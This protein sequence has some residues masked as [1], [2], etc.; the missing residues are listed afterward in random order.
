MTTKR[1]PILPTLVTL[2]NAFCGFTAIDY[3]IRAS[4]DLPRFYHWIGWSGG[5]ILLAMVF[6]ALDGKIARLAHAT[7]DLGRELDSLC[8][9]IS[10]GV[11]PAVIV[12]TLATQQHY[13]P[14]LGW[15]ASVLFVM[16]A[17]LRLARF[18]VETDAAEESHWHFKG[19]PSPAA[20]GF[21][22]ALAVNL[23]EVRGA[24]GAEG[25]LNVER[26]AFSGARAD[27]AHALLPIMDGLLAAVP[28]VALVLALL[29]ISRVRYVH[30]LNKMLRSQEPLDYL[31][32][33]ILMAILAVLTWPYSLPL[34]IGGYVFSGIVLWIKEMVF[35]KAPAAANLAPPAKE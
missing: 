11:A 7:S 24:A 20:A 13:L 18:N 28:Y 15:A 34:F 33:V 21:I 3:A 1:V 30:V 8:D 23:S 26:H 6:D 27:V 2:G 5:L 14:R 31:V 25:F 16:C 19:L 17:A 12:T 32:K 4:A 10:F 22:A 9:V 29:M 35:R